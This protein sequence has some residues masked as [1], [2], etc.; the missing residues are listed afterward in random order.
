MLIELAVAA[1]VIAIG[2]LALLGI[3]HVGER[4]ATD[5]ENETRATLFADEV[6]TTMRLY[7]DHVSANTNHQGW[8]DFWTRVSTGD[9]I[10]PVANTETGTKTWQE[11]DANG[12]PS[13]VGDGTYT[14]PVRTNVWHLADANV[15]DYATSIPDYA[16]QYR[17]AIFRP[18][19]DANNPSVF[20]LD[21]SDRSPI[22]NVVWATLH[23]WNGR[24]RR[25]A[26]PFTFYTHFADPGGLP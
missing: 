25:Q 10:F 26:E 6:F 4:A 23:V 12:V 9:Q 22:T 13:I 17:L 5:T 7:S 14:A 19:T 15:A 1:M 2:V 11:L 18:T 21:D 16:F 20:F 8:L 3:A 24:F